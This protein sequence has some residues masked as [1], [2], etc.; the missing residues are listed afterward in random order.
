MQAI[1]L[2]LS[3]EG[4]FEQQRL[5]LFRSCILHMRQ[6][7]RINIECECD[8]NAGLKFPKSAG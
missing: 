6:N 7:M 2:Q 3:F 5:Y 8:V 1:R 4:R